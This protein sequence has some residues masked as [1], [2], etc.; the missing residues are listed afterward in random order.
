MTVCGSLYLGSCCGSAEGTVQPA[1]CPAGHYCPPGSTLGREFPCPTGTVQS[2]PGASSSV[3]CLPCPPGMELIYYDMLF[4]F[5]FFFT[6]LC[7]LIMLL[8]PAGSFCSSPGLS[9]P[10]GLC[11]AGFYCP[12]GATSPN[13]TALQ[14]FSSFTIALLFFMPHIASLAAIPKTLQTVFFNV[15]S[16]VSGDT[17]RDVKLDQISWAE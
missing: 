13:A 7:F 1:L 15:S 2:Q 4:C 17:W 8:S 5:C 14:V 11:Q 16:S 3:A 10:T 6:L 9:Q 12:A